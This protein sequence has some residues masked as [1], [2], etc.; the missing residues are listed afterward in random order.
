MTWKKLKRILLN[1]ISHS[2]KATYCIIPNKQHSGESKTRESK[3]LSGS[4]KFRR[5]RKEK[6]VHREFLCQ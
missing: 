6:V 4:K 5:G 3:K 2:E 1:E